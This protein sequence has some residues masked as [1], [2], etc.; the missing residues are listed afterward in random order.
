MRAL[1]TALVSVTL[2]GSGTQAQD[3]ALVGRWVNIDQ[4]FTLFVLNIKSDGRVQVLMPAPQFNARYVQ[5]SDRILLHFDSGETDSSFTVTSDTSARWGDGWFIRVSAGPGRTARGTWRAVP[6][7]MNAFMTF[8][9]DG[10]VALEMGILGESQLE[11]NTF[12]ISSNEWPTRALALRRDG[13][14]LYV[15]EGKRREQRYVVR[16][17]GC[18]GFDGESERTGC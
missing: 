4:D 11:G 13:D 17:W 9:P 12:S 18:F 15:A 14:T 16:P 2:L 1:L 10:V 8:R 3:T 5:K 6:A 7:A